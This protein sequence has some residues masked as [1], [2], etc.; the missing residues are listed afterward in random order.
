MSW[1]VRNLSLAERVVAGIFVLFTLS[2]TLGTGEHYFV[3]IVVAVPFSLLVI[4]I[5]ELATR[6]RWRTLTFPLTASLGLM[7]SWI[8][9]LRFAPKL[10]WLSAVVPWGAGL[11]TL[12]LSFLACKNCQVYL[13]LRRTFRSNPE[14]CL[15]PIRAIPR[16]TWFRPTS[17]TSR[18]TNGGDF[19]IDPAAS[20]R[21]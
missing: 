7:V 9:A 17:E 18:R 19:A 12:L 11:A 6:R 1:Y 16:R 4:V 2:A 10:F 21:W 13:L 3:D 15:L 5:A 14:H 8:A 20:A